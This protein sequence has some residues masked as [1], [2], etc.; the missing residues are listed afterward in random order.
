MT[1]LAASEHEYSGIRV[2]TVV[3]ASLMRLLRDCCCVG[4]H[5]HHNTNDAI[6]SYSGCCCIHSCNRKIR[7]T[8]EGTDNST[9]VRSIYGSSQKYQVSSLVPIPPVPQSTPCR[10]YQIRP[11]YL[12]SSAVRHAQITGYVRPETSQY[13]MPKIFDT[14]PV[15]RRER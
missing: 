3:S 10:K 2:G 11:Q 8:L 7:S 14:P 6:S 1:H 9:S 5:E 15:P 4:G 12:S 13:A